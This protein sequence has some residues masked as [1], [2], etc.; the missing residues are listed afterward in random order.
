MIE[1]VYCAF[2]RLPRKVYSKR[3]VNWT[4]VVWSLLVS[5]L[6]MVV[7]WGRF[8][9]KFLVLFAIAVSGAEVFVHLRWR[10][11]LPCPHCGFDPILYKTD[12]KKAARIV[13]ETLDRVK[14]S[15]NYLLKQNNPFEHLP[16]I[17]KEDARHEHNPGGHPHLQ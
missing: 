6:L 7:I 10:L 13:K 12:R 3:H 16:V 2:C 17:R 4:N 9:P 1:K 11:S 15:G 5:L 8:E 14:A